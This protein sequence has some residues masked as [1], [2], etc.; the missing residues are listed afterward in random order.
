VDKEGKERVPHMIIHQRVMELK[1][2]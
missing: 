1:L 2:P